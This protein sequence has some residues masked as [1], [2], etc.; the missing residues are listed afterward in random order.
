MFWKLRKT[1]III[2]SR[3]HEKLAQSCQPIAQIPS[4]IVGVRQH[5]HKESRRAAA[6]LQRSSS[7]R[8]T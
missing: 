5:A 4:A 2:P 7:P 6:T 1:S 3:L 8:M